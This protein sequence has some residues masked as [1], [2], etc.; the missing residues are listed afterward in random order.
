M[1]TKNDGKHL[2]SYSLGTPPYSC[3]SNL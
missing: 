3:I 1:S 2:A